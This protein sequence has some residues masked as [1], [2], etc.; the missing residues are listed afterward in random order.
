M[1]VSLTE[2]IISGDVQ[3]S[4]DVVDDHQNMQLRASSSS[5]SFPG[6]LVVYKV[7]SSYSFSLNKTILNLIH[8][9]CGVLL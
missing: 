3:V 5:I 4:V 6:F 9:K 2:K 8:R 7:R 1:L